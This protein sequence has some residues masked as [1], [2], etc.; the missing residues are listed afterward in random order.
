MESKGK[1]DIRTG[2]RGR[3]TGDH[4]R[5]LGALGRTLVFILRVMGNYW[6]A[7]SGELLKGRAETCSDL[8]FQI[9][10][11]L[12][13]KDLTEEDS[14]VQRGQLSSVHKANKWHNQGQNL[15]IIPKPLLL[16]EIGRWQWKV[17]IF[18]E[19]YCNRWVEARHVQ[20][21]C[22]DLSNTCHFSFYFQS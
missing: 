3:H 8:A 17:K 4:A 12:E 19:K 7:L 21:Y 18:W 20:N 14:K 5:P 11:W 10:L 6:R 1:Y 16:S 22:D 9:W 15:A 13:C 2:Q